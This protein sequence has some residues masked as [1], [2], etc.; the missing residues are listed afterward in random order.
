MTFLANPPRSFPPQAEGR[1]SRQSVDQPQRNI[2]VV[3]CGKRDTISEI[4]RLD[5]DLM[6]NV[7]ELSIEKQ[8]NFTH[9]DNTTLQYYTS[10]ERLLIEDSGLTR[11][12]PNAIKPN[13]QLKTL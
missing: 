7:T 10:L 2:L 13:K 9:L 5:P 1:G 12:D 3:D 6:A 4:P 11:I 8:S